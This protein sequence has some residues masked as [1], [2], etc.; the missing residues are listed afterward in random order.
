MSVANKEQRKT[1][2]IIDFKLSNLYNVMR[3]CEFV[4]LHSLVTSEKKALEEAVGVILPGVGAFGDAMANLEKLDLVG[5]IKDSINSGKPF[6]GIC[7]GLQLLLTESEEFGC[8]HGL[9]MFAG[10]VV[11]FPGV[12]AENQNFKVPQVGWNKISPKEGR[13]W[14]TSMLNGLSDGEYMYFVHSY[15]VVPADEKIVLSQTDYEGIKYCSSIQQGN[16]FACQFHPEKSAAMG[17]NIYHN[18]KKMIDKGG[19]E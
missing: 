19:K 8:H 2:V 5:P 9:D 6:M 1:V 10:K 4:G 18:F 14:S 15:Y 12:S 13:G 3:A 7:L 11:K 17:I 16:V